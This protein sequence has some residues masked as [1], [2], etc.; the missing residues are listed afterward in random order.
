MKEKR[1][2]G[3]KKKRV[4]TPFLAKIP[5]PSFMKKK[6]QKLGNGHLEMLRVFYI[7]QEGT[8]EYGVYAPLALC[9]AMKGV[10]PKA[11]GEMI[12]YA[13]Y[14]A[15]DAYAV[16]FGTVPEEFQEEALASFTAKLD[17]LLAK[18]RDKQRV[19]DAFRFQD[20]KVEER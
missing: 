9:K 12:A 6:M 11:W 10:E 15:I 20:G 19:G 4:R 18:R 17:E 14:S 1:K 16:D 2:K 13:L 5:I 7:L 3:V 8:R